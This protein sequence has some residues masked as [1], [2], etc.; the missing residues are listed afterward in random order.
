MTTLF[1]SNTRKDCKHPDMLHCQAF[2]CEAVDDE[3]HASSVMAQV[4]LW[5]LGVAVVLLFVIVTFTAWR[6]A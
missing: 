1:I 2:G 4:F 5:G 6:F 3:F